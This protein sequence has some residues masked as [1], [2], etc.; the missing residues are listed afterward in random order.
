MTTG[1]GWAGLAGYPWAV[2]AKALTAD[3]KELMRQI[4]APWTNR[5][6]K[7]ANRLTP[8]IV[9]SGKEGYEATRLATGTRGLKKGKEF[10][11]DNPVAALGSVAVIGGPVTRAIGVGSM[12]G[13]IAAANRVPLKG[14]GT[15]AMT[16]TEATKAALVES[17]YPGM[18]DK[19]GI[20]GSPFKPRV[21]GRKVSR[22]TYGRASQ[23]AFDWASEKI[24]EGALPKLGPDTPLRPPGER[25]RER[26]GPTI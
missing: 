25:R 5:N 1:Q 7:G 13:K 14:G 8:A 19:L 22:S 10:W 21:S 6:K 20:E 17:Y 18:L 2:A 24:D 11:H 23:K 26:V 3:D 12:A 16:K 15:R 9:R 4:K